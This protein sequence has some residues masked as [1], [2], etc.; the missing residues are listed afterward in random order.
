MI[1]TFLKYDSNIFID[2]SSSRMAVYLK[3][4]KMA[5]NQNICSNSTSPSLLL[6]QF[7]VLGWAEQP[8]AISMLH[9]VFNSSLWQLILQNM[10]KLLPQRAEKPWIQLP[11]Q[12]THSSQQGLLAQ[13]TLSIVVFNWDWADKGISFQVE[14][15]KLYLYSDNFLF[16]GFSLTGWISGLS[17]QCSLT[18]WNI[19]NGP[20]G[21]CFARSWRDATV[22]LL[23]KAEVEGHSQSSL[24]CFF[25]KEL[26]QTT[27]PA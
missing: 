9:F 2:F 25:C 22:Q 13:P 15:H 10:G 19:P 20:G 12:A 4:K 8:C 23:C 7:P 6:H 1:L 3:G 27:A 5:F 24:L 17:L 26:T 14:K 18:T 11:G 16:V 21:S